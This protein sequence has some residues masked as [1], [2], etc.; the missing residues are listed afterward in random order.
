MPSVALPPSVPSNH[1]LTTRSRAPAADP[2][3]PSSPFA[4]LLDGDDS[5]PAAPAQDRRQPGATTRS[6]PRSDGEA[7]VEPAPRSGEMSDAAEP[8]ET[9]Q[10]PQAPGPDAVISAAMAPIVPAGTAAEAAAGTEAIPADDAG[11][12][13]AATIETTEAVL[14]AAATDDTTAPPSPAGDKPAAPPVP[15]APIVGLAITAAPI[16]EPAIEAAPDADLP[17]AAGVATEP[18]SGASVPAADPIASRGLPADAPNAPAQGAAPADDQPAAKPA[19]A[20]P[21]GN[22]PQPAPAAA[23]AE[24]TV[25]LSA[26]QASAETA[27]ADVEPAPSQ[28]RG[29]EAARPQGR[30]DEPRAGAARAREGAPQPPEHAPPQPRTAETKPAEAAPTSQPAVDLPDLGSLPQPFDRHLTAASAPTAAAATT[31]SAASA[32]AVPVEGLAVEIAARAQGGRNRFEIRLD[33]PE[34]GR[35]DVRLDVDRSGHVTSRLIVERA[36][37]LDILRRDAGELERALQQAGL[38]T[39]DN[40]LQFTL[41]DQAFAG[42]DDERAPDAAR[43]VVPAAGTD[44]LESGQRGYGRMLRL[45]GGI[46][47]R[48]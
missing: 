35:I 9:A 16:T 20:T 13:E 1:D 39:S 24:T 18:M 36:E 27:P 45:G 26:A 48:V 19:A 10:P 37:T 3:R 4:A 33:P 6:A 12:D 17:I 32:P 28:D 23:A 44:A 30:S 46:D 25:E 5:P 15:A 41:R 8:G 14:F 11:D 38:K 40:G 2:G 47:I 31:S 21:V 29:G 7:R 43:L 22:R 34:L 42:R